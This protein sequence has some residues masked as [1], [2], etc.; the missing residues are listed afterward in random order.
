MPKKTTDQ[1]RVDAI[2]KLP[3]A[4]RKRGLDMIFGALDKRTKRAQDDLKS[5]KN[6]QKVIEDLRKKGKKP[7]GKKVKI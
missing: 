2:M 6:Q 5:L 3:P 1:L 7:V 4:Q